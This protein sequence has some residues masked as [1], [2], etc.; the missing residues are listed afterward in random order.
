MRNRK[1]WLLVASVIV[2]IM[3]T[4]MPFAV[5]CNNNQQSEVQTLKVGALFG[6]TGFFS[7]FDAV[8]AAEAQLAVDMINAD[9][10]IKV[11]GQQYNI[12]LITY[13]FKSNMDGVSAGA[14]ELVFQDGV[15]YMIAPSAFFSP[16]HREL[17]Q[18]YVRFAF[19]KN[20]AT[21][22]EAANRMSKLRG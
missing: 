2:A 15:K 17:T 18:N 4:I 5:G 8:Q 11:Q 7:A 1:F 6:L 13:D 14:N 19:C 21:L 9:G 12:E 22:E 10:G 20:D 16:Q 3:V